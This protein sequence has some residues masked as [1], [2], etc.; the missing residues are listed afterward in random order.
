MP[1]GPRIKSSCGMY[2]V[3]L[4][5]VN[6]QTIFEDEEDSEKFLFLLK[7]YSERSGFRIHAWCLMGNHVHILLEIVNEPIDVALKKVGTCYAI[8]FNTKYQRTG[9]LFQGRFGSEAVEDEEYYMKVLRYIHMNPVKAGICL[10]PMDYE[11]SSYRE[12]IGKSSRRL[13]DTERVMSIM[14]IDSFISF[15]IKENDDAVLDYSD[16]PKGRM[17]DAAA[18][19]IIEDITGCR[20][21]SEFQALGTRTRD[22]AFIAIIKRGVSINQAAR[23]TGW[24]RTVI[25]RT[26]KKVH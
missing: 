12:Y 3:I 7:L 20:N 9:H 15:T 2:H 8:Y 22:I 17:S 6:R 1:R 4:R 21:A 24:S 16:L 14:Q 26:L 19:E 23:I 10:N 11:Y 25:R 5:G 13:V 18:K